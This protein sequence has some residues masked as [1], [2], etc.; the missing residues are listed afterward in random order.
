MIPKL[1]DEK[2]IFC[3]WVYKIKKCPNGL[4][5]R[6]KTWLVAQGFSQ[7]YGLD[8]NGTFSSVV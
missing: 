3:K 2:P 5:E 4:V 6:Y 8:Y 1:E 7:Q